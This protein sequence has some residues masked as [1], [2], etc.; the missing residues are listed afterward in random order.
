MA[1]AQDKAQGCCGGAPAGKVALPAAAK[2]GAA[3]EEVA[4]S[5]PTTAKALAKGRCET[6]VNS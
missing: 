1:A 3:K 4:D 5:S 6:I 2:G